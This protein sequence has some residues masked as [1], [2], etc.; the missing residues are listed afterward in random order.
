MKKNL[1]KLIHYKNTYIT[2]QKTS[3]RVINLCFIILFQIKMRK[4]TFYF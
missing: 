3:F 4:K 2:Q 1:Q